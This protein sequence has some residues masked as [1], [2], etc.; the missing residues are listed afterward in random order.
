MTLFI[1]IR[2]APTKSPTAKNILN[3]ITQAN[4]I[5]PAK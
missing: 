2:I 5:S 1:N 3:K 4:K